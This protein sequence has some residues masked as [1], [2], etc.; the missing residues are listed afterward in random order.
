MVTVK[1]EQHR[2]LLPLCRSLLPHEMNSYE[3][4]VMFRLSHSSDFCVLMFR[5]FSLRVKSPNLKI[6]YNNQLFTK[7]ALYFYNLHQSKNAIKLFRENNIL[8]AVLSSYVEKQKLYLKCHLIHQNI[9]KQS[10]MLAPS[11]PKNTKLLILFCKLMNKL[12][13]SAF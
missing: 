5:F 1:E 8:S 13:T 6:M 2:W 3:K 7:I 10:V 12:Q 11:P 9:P 4:T